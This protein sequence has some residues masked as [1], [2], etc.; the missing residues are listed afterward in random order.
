MDKSIASSSS[1]Q[2]HSAARVSGW[3]NGRRRSLMQILWP[4]M[5]AS[6]CR[7]IDDAGIGRVM[8][9]DGFGQACDV[10]QAPHLSVGWDDD[11]EASTAPVH[12]LTGESERGHERGV[13][14]RAWGEVDEHSTTLR[15][16]GE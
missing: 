3:P 12:F 7:G 1:P 4:S 2:G 15:G 8:D 16:L 13:C 10:C 14:E 11:I 9:A 5:R 6:G